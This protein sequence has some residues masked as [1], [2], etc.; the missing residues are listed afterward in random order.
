MVTNESKIYFFR[1]SYTL[2]LCWMHWFVSHLIYLSLTKPTMQQRFHPSAEYFLHSGQVQA[3][4]WGPFTTQCDNVCRG[5]QG[6]IE[7]IHPPPTK[8]KYRLKSFCE[9]GYANFRPNIL[10]LVREYQWRFWYGWGCM[11]G[12]Q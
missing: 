12:A 11:H 5:Q 10:L 4:K 6:E 2:R 8:S 7:R 3:S 1:D 9:V